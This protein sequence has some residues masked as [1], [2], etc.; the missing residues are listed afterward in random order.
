M[1][2]FVYIPFENE[3]RFGFAV[4]ILV[5]RVYPCRYFKRG[6][7]EAGWVAYMFGGPVP[8]TKL[9]RCAGRER[10]GDIMMTSFIKRT[11]SS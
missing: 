3:F 10:K 7:S 11:G 5:P 1:S 6:R 9:H 4:G 8:T 2:G